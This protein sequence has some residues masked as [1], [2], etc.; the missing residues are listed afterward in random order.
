MLDGIV[1]LSVAVLI[2]RSWPAPGPDA[3]GAL[4]GIGMV[5]SGFTRVAL[6]Y[7]DFGSRRGRGP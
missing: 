5:T 1:S 2:W 3:V 6:G 4:V 7:T